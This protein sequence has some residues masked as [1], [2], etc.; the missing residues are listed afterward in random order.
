MAL[1]IVSWLL[2][3]PLLGVTT[4]L[5]SL[6]PIALLCWFAYNGEVSVDGTWAAW[7]ARLWVAILFTVLA[8]GELAADKCSW[9]PNRVSPGPLLARLV[10]GGLVGS[11][12]ATAME[13]PGLEGVLLGVLG[14]MLGAFGGFMVRR[15]L[16]EKQGWPDW[17]IAVLEDVLAISAS[18]ISLHVVSS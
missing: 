17:Q 6:T 15:R 18:L 3:I 12:A 16:V 11:I 9:I 4:G 5:R 7:T 13:G 1:A 2:A 14:A 8:V 10:L